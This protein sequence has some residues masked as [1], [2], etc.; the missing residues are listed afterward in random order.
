MSH[1]GQVALEQDEELLILDSKKKKKFGSSVMNWMRKNSLLTLTMLGV[2]LGLI[3]GII[4]NKIGISKTMTI[5]VGFPGEL[6]LRMLKM[7]VLPLIVASVIVGITSLSSGQEFGRTEKRVFY[8]VLIYFA[9]TTIVAVILGVVIV[10]VLQPGKFSKGI[11]NPEELPEDD[12]P[13]EIPPNATPLDS[14]LSVLRSMVPENI[15]KSSANL[16]ILGVLTF[17]ILL[18]ATIIVLGEKGKPLLEFFESLNEAI[19]KIVGFVMWYAPFGIM[20]LIAARLGGNADFVSVLQDIA[21][22]A[23]TVIAGLSI[24]FFIILPTL[25]FVFLRKNPFKFYIFMLQV[26]LTAIGTD[27]SAATL[28]V[29]IEYTK[30]FGVNSK[31]VQ[32]VLPLGVTLNMNGTALYEAVAAMFVAQ[33]HGI[34]LNAG[35]TIIVALTSTL[36]AVGA[37]GIPEA[38]LITMTMV[39]TAV[40][41]P[42]SDIGLLLTIDWFLDRMR[43]VVNCLSDSICAAIVDSYYSKELL[44]IEQEKKG[45][46]TK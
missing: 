7:L 41:L 3:L 46:V 28:P 45:E 5:L 17:S 2:L 34:K 20:S 8:R 6:L 15:V 10:S 36:A 23:V 25:Y 43:T 14:I 35:Q 42:L 12:N 31:I 37:A 33:L 29:N 26:I 13:G 38:G 9:S 24:H 19:M 27:S 30:K 39:F 44:L 1:E 22:F 32:I 4:L 21:M 40:G 16:D 18:G 11:G